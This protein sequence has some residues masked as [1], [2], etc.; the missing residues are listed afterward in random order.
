M[1]AKKIIIVFILVLILALATTIA[2]ASGFALATNKE[3]IDTVNSDLDFKEFEEIAPVASP[4]RGS[5][6]G[7]LVYTGKTYNTTAFIHASRSAGQMNFHLEIGQTN[8][9]FKYDIKFKIYNEQGSVVSSKNFVHDPIDKTNVGNEFDLISTN[10]GDGNYRLEWSGSISRIS[11]SESQS[12]SYSFVI[13]NTN[14]ILVTSIKDNA[15]VNRAVNFSVS[16]LHPSYVNAGL[17][18]DGE[19]HNYYTDYS[20]ELPTAEDKALNKVITYTVNATDS[21]FN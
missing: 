9:S 6:V 1:R 5:S 21:Y 17:F 14:P 13:D 15:I 11:G 20:L 19:Y 16:D 7:E 4:R 3:T 18:I 2:Y 10:Y 12:G 8:A